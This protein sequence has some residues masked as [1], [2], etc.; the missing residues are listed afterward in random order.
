MASLQAEEEQMLSTQGRGPVC[1]AHC[2][3]HGIRCSADTR[4]HYLETELQVG[5]AWKLHIPDSIRKLPFWV[6]DWAPGTWL[7]SPIPLS[8]LWKIEP[9]F[10]DRIMTHILQS[11]QPR[12]FSWHSQG[13]VS[14]E[15]GLVC[16]PESLR[17]Y[18]L[19]PFSNCWAGYQLLDLRPPCALVCIR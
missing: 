1:H 15:Q 2:C 19:S 13:H 5:S 17:S 10:G 4:W 12:N 11:C 16:K 18:S 8:P 14:L 6:T 7:S 9:L 3:S